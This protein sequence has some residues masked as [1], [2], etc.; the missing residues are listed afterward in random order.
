MQKTIADQNSVIL[1]HTGS[2]ERKV[3]ERTRELAIANKELEAFSYTVSHDLKAPLRSIDGFSRALEEDYGELLDDTARD[4]L[5]RVRVGSYKMSQ[6]ITSLL[7][8]AKVARQELNK[9][10]IDLTRLSEN[11]INELR[12]ED[13]ERALVINIQQGM[14]ALGDKDLV[15]VVLNNL[16]GNAWKYSKTKSETHIDIGMSEQKGQ[17]IYYVKDNGVGFNMKYAD[18]LLK[19]FNRLHSADEFEGSGIGLATVNRII[20]RHHGK[21]WVES[22]IDKGSKFYFT[23]FP[24]SSNT[25]TSELSRKIDSL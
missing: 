15:Q 18:Q 17:Q 12:I 1:E 19:P 4:Y 24:E 13:P 21:I 8:L 9:D 7:Q 2:L 16:I 14:E 20:E 22:E 25:E 3:E 11:T 5:L 10:E 6:L 23:L